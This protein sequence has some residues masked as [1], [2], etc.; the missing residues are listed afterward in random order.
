TEA[1]LTTILD[2]T[3]PLESANLSFCLGCHTV[4]GRYYTTGGILGAGSLVNWLVELYWPQQNSDR[5]AAY[6]TLSQLAA[7]S[8]RG[9]NGLYLLPH[10][11][12]AGSPDR[13]STARGVIA[14]LSLAHKRADLARAVLEGLAYELKALWLT[15]E[16]FTGQPV[17][18]VVT[19]G[20]GARNKLWNQTKADITG[21]ELETPGHT[22]AV[23]RGAALLAGIGAGIYRDTAEA[24]QRTSQPIYVTSPDPD[25]WRYYQQ[26]WAYIEQLRREAVQLGRLSGDLLVNQQ[27]SG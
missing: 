21:K 3:A 24:Q 25:A 17:S 7:S 13:S 10:L 27:E 15:L 26:H 23:T 14:G 9:A 11:A 16:R 2:V 1:E 5:G 22:E 18:R 20:G 8:P 19:V 6:E 4:P 12:G